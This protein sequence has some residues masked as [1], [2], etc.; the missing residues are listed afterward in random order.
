[1]ERALKLDGAQGRRAVPRLQA[2]KNAL[3]GIL[4]REPGSGTGVKGA[5]GAGVC[6]TGLGMEATF[7]AL[8]SSR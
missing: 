5:D 4:G 3:E 7:L 8:A 1:M 2:T 6:R